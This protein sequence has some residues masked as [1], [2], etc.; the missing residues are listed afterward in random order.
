MHDNAHFQSQV[1]DYL[2]DGLRDLVLKS[3]TLSDY[4]LHCSF[5]VSLDTISND[6]GKMSDS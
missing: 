3:M 4:L 5:G 1:I 2:L 6:L